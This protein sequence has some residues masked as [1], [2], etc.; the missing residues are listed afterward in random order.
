MPGGLD[1]IEFGTGDGRGVVMC[2]RYWDDPVG[3]APDDQGRRGDR[4]QSAQEGLVAH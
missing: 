2:V 4:R 3:G 1:E